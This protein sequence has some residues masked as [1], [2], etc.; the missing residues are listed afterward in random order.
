MISF[1]VC[2]GVLSTTLSCFGSQILAPD[3]YS[4]KGFCEALMS[5]SSL[6]ILANALAAA[7]ARSSTSTTK[8]P[9]QPPR[10]IKPEPPPLV[11]VPEPKPEQN[12]DQPRTKRPSIFGD[13]YRGLNAFIVPAIGFQNRAQAQQ[14]HD[15]LDPIILSDAY[16]SFDIDDGRRWYV[17]HTWTSSGSLNDYLVH[18]PR[19]FGRPNQPQWLTIWKRGEKMPEGGYTVM[20]LAGGRRQFYRHQHR[21]T[22]HPGWWYRISSGPRD[23]FVV[24]RDNQGQEMH[25]LESWAGDR[26][27]YTTRSARAVAY[28]KVQRFANN[29]APDGFDVFVAMIKVSIRDRNTN[30]DPA[31]MIE[32]RNRHIVIPAGEIFMVPI[33]EDLDQIWYDMTTEAMTGFE[34][35]CQPVPAEVEEWRQYYL[36]QAAKAEADNHDYSNASFR[37]RLEKLGDD[38]KAGLRLVREAWQLEAVIHQWHHRPEFMDVPGTYDGA[39]Y[40]HVAKM[41]EQ[42]KLPESRLRELHQM[43]SDF[44]EPRDNL[45]NYAGD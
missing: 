6:N 16:T 8:K 3:I 42:S 26:H 37:S 10:V 29:G 41:L 39:K 11:A 14:F 2:R 4:K 24:W 12:P 21:T 15:G 20:V 19:T 33:S 36:G 35:F 45:W 31:I 23:C 25:G 32:V 38:W 13:D 27:I 18:D 9:V 34:K 43:I 28:A 30:M 44:V 7:G 22:K 40:T 17:P 5:N 1:N